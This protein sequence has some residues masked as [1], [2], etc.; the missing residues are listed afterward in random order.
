MTIA[1][2]RLVIYLLLVAFS[3]NDSISHRFR[4]ITTF[5]VYV[6]G[7]DLAKCFV[8]V[9]IVEITSYVHFSR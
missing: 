1:S 8:F 5:T 3:N 9:K 7:C 6:T 2:I 4:D